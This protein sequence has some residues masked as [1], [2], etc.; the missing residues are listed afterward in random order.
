[1][2]HSEPVDY[3]TVV[4]GSATPLFGS[5]SEIKYGTFQHPKTFESLQLYSGLM[6]YQTTLPSDYT[7]RGYL[8]ADKLHDRTIVYV[9]NVT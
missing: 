4:F 3:G 2:D 7:G 9:N 8:V 1:M 6:L 5:S